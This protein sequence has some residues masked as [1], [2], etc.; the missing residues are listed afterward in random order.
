[1]K[2][3]LSDCNYYL[4]EDTVARKMATELMLSMENMNI[5][6]DKCLQYIYRCLVSAFISHEKNDL[7]GVL[8]V[9]ENISEWL[10]NFSLFTPE[11]RTK[12]KNPFIV[13]LNELRLKEIEGK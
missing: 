10:M 3:K 11:F 2:Q 13:M 4:G 6:S 5:L 8:L 7:N 1:M 12:V 9:Y